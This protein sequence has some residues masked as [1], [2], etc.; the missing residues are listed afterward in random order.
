MD[1]K[2]L[3]TSF[4]GRINRGKFWAGI[5]VFIVIGVIAFILDAILG[6]RVTTA[7]GA[8][9]GIIGILFALAS[10]YFAIALYAKRWHDRNK[11][12][13]WTLIGFVPVIGGIWLLVE[14]GILEG[15]R[16]ANQY[17]SDPLA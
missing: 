7:S 1:W 17:G 8:Q 3:L 4:D 10:I 6:T 16:G 13:W 5:G 2:Y 11:S 15:T 9:I 12:G 14:L